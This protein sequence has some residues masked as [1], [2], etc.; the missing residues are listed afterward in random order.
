MLAAGHE[1]RQK[2]AIRALDGT[3]ERCNARWQKWL[4]A[5][6]RYDDVN[7]E[8]ESFNR[9]YLFERNAA[10]KYVPHNQVDPQTR[11]PIGPANLIARYPFASIPGANPTA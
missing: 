4:D 9:N 3:I 1:R 2:R 11:D 6:G 10:L 8:I 7:A 5:D